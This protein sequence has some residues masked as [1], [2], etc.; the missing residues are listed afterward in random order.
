MSQP[1]TVDIIRPDE[2]DDRLVAV[3]RALLAANPALTSP[4]FQPE[5]TTIG[6]AVTPGA[7]VAVLHRGGE[8]RGFF[9]HQRRG[10]AVQP[11]AAPLNDYHGVIARPG[12]APDLSRV[13]RLL[14]AGRLN[15]GGW[16]GPAAAGE[17]RET[18]QA[19]MPDGYD[20]WYAERRA[21]FGKY[22]KD[23]ERARRSLE[24]ELGPIRVEVGLRDAGLLDHL[25]DLKREQY[26]RT[27][28]H[29]VFACGWTRD[30]LH[31]LMAAPTGRFGVSLGAL[32]GGDKLAAIEAS[33]HGGDEYHF[34]F[35]AYEPKWARCSPGI[36]LSM[37][38]MRL[39]SA[40]GYRTFDYGFQGEGYKKYFCD[41]RR[42]VAEA[43]VVRP[44]LASAVSGA[45]V[46]LLNLAGQG[47]G[48]RLRASVR[49][50]WAVI[51]A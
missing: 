4:Y 37:D 19:V 3:W 30:L 27:G 35:P 33:L 41:G 16:V 1:L 50:R 2:L 21:A 51:E 43:V 8:V 34:W 29:D 25:I 42:Q 49:R 14:K 12:E 44:G 38:T 24:A 36:L 13:A 15:V 9:P 23:K 28:R 32:W 46:G 40:H 18:V 10:S 5:F 47:R 45:A 7:A 22:F 31:A 17:A 48:E 11:L 26:R 39:A 20:A 6:G